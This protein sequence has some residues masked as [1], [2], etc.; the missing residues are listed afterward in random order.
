[1]NTDAGFEIDLFGEIANLMTFSGGP[2]TEEFRRSVKVVAGERVS[3]C[4][5]TI[6]IGC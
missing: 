5:Q 2:K 6:A 3:Q 1:M 4:S